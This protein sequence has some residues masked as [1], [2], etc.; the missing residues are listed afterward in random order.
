[1]DVEDSMSTP[2]TNASQ[3]DL[4]AELERVRA[5]NEQLKAATES[6][7]SASR[8]AWRWIG[9][10]ALLLIGLL[11]FALAIPTVWV[12]RTIMDTDQWVAT[13][14]PLAQNAAIQDA[15]AEKVST[16][17]FAKVDVEAQIRSVLPTALAPIAAPVAGQVETYADK[18]ITEVVRSDQ[19]SNI[20]T[21]T[22]RAAQQAFVAAIEG[23]RPGG[24]VSTTNGVITFNTDAFVT[25]AQERLA[26]TRI[27]GLTKYIPWDKFPDSFVL[28]ESPR[29]AQAQTVF[30]LFNSLVWVL[31]VLAL[32]FLA[33]AL[34]A[35]PN[36]RRAWLW[37][38]LGL[39]IVTLLPFE[40]LVFARTAFIS[41]AYAS[42]EI[43]TDAAQSF[44]DIVFRFLVTMQTTAITVGLVVAAI[45][46]FAGPAKLALWFRHGI[47]RGMALARG[48]SDFGQFGE[49]VAANKSALR[50]GAVAL[51][52]LID[53]LSTPLTPR[54]V[55]GTAIFV[56][57]LVLL[58]EF[59]G[60]PGGMPMPPA[61]DLGASDAEMMAETPTD[62]N[63][64]AN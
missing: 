52:V 14:G 32:I 46:F 59:F 13:V 16:A 61:G 55:I 17:L 64:S 56:G 19:F 18:L 48:D 12:N 24:A 39:V 37:L 8:H 54:F 60:Q 9:A 51:G 58:V 3:E 28:Y 34:W 5:E 33:L 22:M 31:P 1:M 44:W 30:G 15:V 23:G 27:S 26:S 29:L 62:A 21:T 38:G 43:P 45:A 53:V 57:I 42:A 10:I 49:F 63:P 36:T 41:A 2:A 25:A 35:A 7:H 40:A 4:A 47:A 11:L 6:K 50:V 20:W